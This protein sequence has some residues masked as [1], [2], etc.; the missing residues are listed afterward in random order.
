[1]QRREQQ[2]RAG[3]G[4]GGMGMG[5]GIGG[6]M[7]GYSSVP[8]FEPQA[9]SRITT[10]SPSPAPARAPAFKSAGMKLGSKKTKQA[11]LLDALGGDMAS[12][13]MAD[14]STPPTPSAPEPAQ[15]APAAKASDERGSV[16]EVVQEGYV[17]Y[18]VLLDYSYMLIIHQRTPVHQRKH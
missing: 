11:E 2:R 14:M 16:P 15:Q 18:L 12:S 13:L 9:P 10:A 4:G 3:G 1:M 8:R 17:F 7:S 6:G 5:M